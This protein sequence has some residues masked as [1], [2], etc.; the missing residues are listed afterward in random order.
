MFTATQGRPLLT[1]N[2]YRLLHTFPKEPRGERDEHPDFQALDETSCDRY[3]ALYGLF[4]DHT[5]DREVKDEA[6]LQA[7]T[8]PSVIQDITAQHV[9][10][11]PGKQEIQLLVPRRLVEQR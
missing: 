8:D 1:T 9:I 4:A 3:E 7:L 10:I 2:H 11:R 5:G 6:L